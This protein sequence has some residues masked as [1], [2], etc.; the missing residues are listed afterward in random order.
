MVARVDPYEVLGVAR[1]VDMHE[2]R[3]AYRRASLKYHPDIYP[4]DPAEGH[5]RFTEITNAYRIISQAI[6]EGRVISPGEMWAPRFSPQDFTRLEVGW[7]F[8]ESPDRLPDAS[9]IGAISFTRPTVDEPRVFLSLWALAVTISLMT[10][11]LVIRFGAIGGGLLD[12]L[13]VLPLTIGIYA[14]VMVATVGIL[15]MTRKTMLMIRRLGWM[16][17]RSLPG[18]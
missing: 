10:V 1:G 8:I 18:R 12:Y 6:R 17:R 2:L 15:Q 11:Y 14:M 9:S 5:R 13:T 4:G 16:G 3:L 7:S